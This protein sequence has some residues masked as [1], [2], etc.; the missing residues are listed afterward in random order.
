MLHALHCIRYYACVELPVSS[1]CTRTMAEEEKPPELRERHK[2]E[3][4]VRCTVTLAYWWLMD[5]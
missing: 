1:H 5:R 4:Q 2:P 3:A